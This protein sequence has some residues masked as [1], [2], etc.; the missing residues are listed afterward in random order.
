MLAEEKPNGGERSSND[1]DVVMHLHLFRPRRAFH[2][3]D[4]DTA[5]CLGMLTHGGFDGEGRRFLAYTAMMLIHCR[6]IV[7]MVHVNFLVRVDILCTCPS[8]LA[9]SSDTNK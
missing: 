4:A 9:K 7:A 3:L 8:I 1:L 2:R 5:T 6:W